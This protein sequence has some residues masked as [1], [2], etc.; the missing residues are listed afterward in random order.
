MSGVRQARVSL[1]FLVFGVSVSGK[2]LASRSSF[3][4]AAGWAA[5][6]PG[7]AMLTAGKD[8][9]RVERLPSEGRLPC[10]ACGGGCGDGACPAGCDPR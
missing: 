2:S 7:G 8:A 6:A 1:P 5:E 4:R 9:G 3:G 10:P